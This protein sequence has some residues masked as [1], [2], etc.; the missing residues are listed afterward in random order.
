MDANTN[1]QVMALLEHFKKG[2]PLHIKVQQLPACAVD[3]A[4]EWA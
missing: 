3:A 4:A 2:E 1:Q